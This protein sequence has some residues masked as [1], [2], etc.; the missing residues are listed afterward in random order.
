MTRPRSLQ[1]R[2]ARASVGRR[3]AFTATVFAA[4][5]GTV[6][7]AA[8]TTAPTATAAEPARSVPVINGDFT[9][10]SFTASGSGDKLRGWTVQYPYRLLPADAAHPDNLPALLLRNK[11]AT[12]QSVSQRL[13][14][15]RTGA[16]V[17][18]TFDDNTGACTGA[19]LAN[20]QPYT[21]QGSGGPQQ[22]I[23]TDPGSTDW[24]RGRTYTFTAGENE[25][26]ITFASTQTTGRWECGPLIAKV[27]ATHVPPLVDK[28]VPKNR[29]PAP[30]A[31][32]GNNRI[33]TRTAADHCASARNNCT[34]TVDSTYSYTYYDKARIIG[35]T[36]LNCTRNT[37]EHD[38][39]V[40]F[41]GRSQDNLSQQAGIDRLPNLKDNLNQQF[42]T[43]VTKSSSEP[44]RWTTTAD[45]KIHEIIEAGEASWIEAQP[46]RQRTDGWFTSDTDDPDKQIRLYVVADGPSPLVPDRIYQRTGPM[47][48]AEQQRC[49]SDRPTAPT[50]VDADAPASATDRDD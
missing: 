12:D 24:H 33:D 7:A 46:G 18:I 25:P 32:E 11:R 22:K 45:R 13:R 29:L 3:P 9:E 35:E 10:P 21:L 31:F 48:S 4:V 17:T 37:V 47:T 50:P 34:Y 38:R 14:G 44:W 49:R 39:P 43:G 20:G 8:A 41:T 19:Q 40:R 27:R 36:Y 2:T 28:T 42:E 26:L 15:V 6:L 1:H 5:A 23:T 16:K 30:E